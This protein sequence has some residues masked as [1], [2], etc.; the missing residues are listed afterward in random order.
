MITITPRHDM[1]QLCYTVVDTS[2]GTVYYLARGRYPD[3]RPVIID[4]ASL[5]RSYGR[6]KVSAPERFG[7]WANPGQFREWCNNYAHNRVVSTERNPFTV[8]QGVGVSR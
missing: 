5:Y 6:V 1:A 4:A 3:A 7:R 2:N 8:R